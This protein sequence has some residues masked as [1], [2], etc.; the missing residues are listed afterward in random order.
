MSFQRVVGLCYG[1]LI[2][3]GLGG[4]VAGCG[5]GGSGQV[6][7]SKEYMSKTQDMLNKMPDMMK[8]QALAKQAAQK[9]ARTGKGPGR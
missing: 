6:E 8:Q 5:S 2:V 4:A 7:V 3:V 9:A 1:T